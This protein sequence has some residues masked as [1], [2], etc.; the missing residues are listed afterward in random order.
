MASSGGDNAKEKNACKEAHVATNKGEPHHSRDDS[1]D[2]VSK[3]GPDGDRLVGEGKGHDPIRGKRH[4][5]RGEAKE[6]SRGGSL[7]KSDDKKKWI[8]A[9]TIVK[10][11]VTSV[12]EM[13]RDK[14]SFVA[15]RN[16]TSANSRIVLGLEAS[17]IDI[18]AMAE[19]LLKASCCLPTRRRCVNW[20]STWQPLDSSMPLVR[21]AY[22]FHKC[23]YDKCMETKSLPR[24][25]NELMVL[26]DNFMNH[27]LADP[28][29]VA[30]KA[31]H[32]TS[33]DA[34]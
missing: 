14:P 24:S 29:K 3:N 16:G 10:P 6:G 17:A 11:M 21:S 8:P 23:I 30:E 27:D 32:I 1:V 15:P 18:L 22:L 12:R 5:Y 31:L 26:G 9:K 28:F 19:K 25:L 33:S 2:D 4:S 7:L 13:I 34:P 20:S